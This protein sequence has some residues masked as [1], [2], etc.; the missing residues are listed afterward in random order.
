M[1]G[2]SKW[3]NI[4]H[5]KAKMDAQKGKI[6]TRY[7]KMII[8]AAKE[9][10]A[11]PDTN[12]RLKDAIEKAKEVNMP[13][14]NIERAIKKGSG[15]LDGVNYEE[16][17][18]EGYGPGGVAILIDAMTDNRNRTAGEFRHIF[19]KNGGNLGESGCVAWMFERKG[20]IIIE[21]DESISAD[22]IMMISIEAGAEDIEEFDDSIEISTSP[23]Q[24]REVRKELEDN[25]I[26]PVS[27]EV[28]YVPN[29]YVKLSGK[30]K[31]TMERLLETLEEHDDVQ[32]VYS[33]YEDEDSE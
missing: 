7:S 16:I 6:Y 9:G 24:L 17:M 32:N 8:L 27:A 33:N 21:K 3:S 18:Y 15:D 25:G 10:G 5:K 31:D 30:Q 20:L 13:N 2:H 28:T 11:D 4:K 1:A 26:K 14:D 23:D 29:T 19:D 22:D 12:F